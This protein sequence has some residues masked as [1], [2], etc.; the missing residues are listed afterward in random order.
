MR[1]KNALAEKCGLNYISALPDN[2]FTIIMKIAL[3]IISY[4]LPPI[5][6][7]LFFFPLVLSKQIHLF[8]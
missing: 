5:L 3:I 6:N 4:F 8:P 2:Y 1:K 7:S